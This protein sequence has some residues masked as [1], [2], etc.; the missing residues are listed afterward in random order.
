MQQIQHGYPGR[1]G[2]RLDRV[3]LNETITH[4][5]LGGQRRRVYA[6]I[7]AL[8]G[9]HPGDRILDVGC[10]GGYLARPAGRLRRPG[11]PGHRGRSVGRGSPLRPAVGPGQL[12][13][14]ARRGA[15]PGPAGRVIRRGDQHAGRAPHPRSGAGGRVRRDVPGAA[16]GRRAAGRRL[17]PGRPG[18]TSRPAVACR[19]CVTSGPSSPCLVV[20]S[21]GSRCSSP[22]HPAHDRSGSC[23]P[24]PRP[25]ASGAWARRR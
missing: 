22:G 24:S 2:A 19:C 3:R 20:S 17:P 16:P 15:G 11:R 18:S 23:R 13:I 1:E 25:A 10:G 6:R 7:T 9:A 5:A 4:A 12:L 8:S 14:S 21:P